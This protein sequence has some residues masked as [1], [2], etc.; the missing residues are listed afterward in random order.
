MR[1]AT[2]EERESV[3]N[4]VDS[5]SKPTGITFDEVV[6]NSFNFGSPQVKKM[7]STPLLMTDAVL[8]RDIIDVIS[9]ADPS[10]GTEKVFSGKEIIDLIKTLQPVQLEKETM[11]TDLGT[12]AINKNVH[13]YECARCHHTMM[14]SSSVIH[15]PECGAKVIEIL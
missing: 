8:I 9:G 15:C 1:D 13:I 12:H 3:K 10:D 11:F 14:I 7:E 2:K 4:Y 5:I 6:N